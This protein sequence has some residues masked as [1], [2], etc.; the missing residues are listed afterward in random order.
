[1]NG[2]ILVLHMCC[3]SPGLTAGKCK[4]KSDKLY[5]CRNRQGITTSGAQDVSVIREGLLF[6]FLQEQDDMLSR[7]A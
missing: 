1:M 3:F 4:V 2:N 5:S 7:S 6:P